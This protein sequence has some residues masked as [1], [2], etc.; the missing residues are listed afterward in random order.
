MTAPAAPP[1]LTDEQ[2]AALEQDAID[3]RL[4]GIWGE[5]LA[6]IAEVRS[7]RASAE[8]AEGL[9]SALERIEWVEVDEYDY[10]SALDRT[11]T[12][13]Q[14]PACGE[15]HPDDPDGGGHTLTC[16]TH[17]ALAAYRGSR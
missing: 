7:S 14:C 10:D 12:R 13:R 11:V 4:G 3:G 1:R 6:L 16:S 8:R 2:I 9:A 5:I 15:Y 17:R